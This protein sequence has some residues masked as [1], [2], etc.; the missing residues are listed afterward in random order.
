[1]MN[2]WMGTNS[3]VWLYLCMERNI[4]ESELMG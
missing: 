3:M 2:Q 1:M 4:H